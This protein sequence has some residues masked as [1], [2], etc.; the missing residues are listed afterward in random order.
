MVR[1]ES[2]DWQRSL[3]DTA[4]VLRAFGL[5][6]H[7]RVIIGLPGYPWDIG[8]VFAFAAESCGAEVWC[9]GSAFDHSQVQD[10]WLPLRPHFLILPPSKL[11]VFD[12]TD[13]L[14]GACLLAVGEP[15]SSELE[16]TLIERHGLAR[17]RRIYGHSELGTLAYQ[18]IDKSHTMRTNPRFAFHLSESGSLIVCRNGQSELVDTGDIGR[19]LAPNTDANGLWSKTPLLDITSRNA[20]HEFIGGI[21]LSETCIESFRSSIGAEFVQVE[22]GES[23]ADAPKLLIRVVGI[24]LPSTQEM[25]RALYRQ[26]FELYDETSMLKSEEAI[27]IHFQPCK[28]QELKSTPRGKTPVMIRAGVSTL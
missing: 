27:S 9:L 28:L 15:V 22:I 12:R 24:H 23:C 11:Q 4:E 18:H 1:R 20:F 3:Y 25:Y 16:Q 8:E 2:M 13:F 6:R 17:V 26:L 14:S 7:E 5:T 19:L 10:L 21:K